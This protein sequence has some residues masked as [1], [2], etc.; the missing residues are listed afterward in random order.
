MEEKLSRYR[1]AIMGFAILWIMV[2][3][4]KVH[5]TFLPPLLSSALT[6]IKS[7]GYGGVELFLFLSGFG[8]YQS[9]V[10]N[11][12]VLTFYARRLRRIL[13]AYLPVLLLWLCWK[14]PSTA[15]GLWP[16]IILGNLTGLGFW[17]SAAPLFNWYI[18]SLFA[19]Y[20]AAPL[21][22]A[23]QERYGVRGEAAL[24]LGSAV[25]DVCFLGSYLM[26]AVS[27]FTIFLLGMIFS[28]RCV[29]GKRCT[30]FCELFFYAAGMGAFF[31]LLWLRST[32]PEL[33][34]GYGLYWYPFL[35]LGI[36]L[37]YF[38]CRVFSLL[39]R[40]R[41]G[42]AVEHFFAL[43][44]GCSLELYLLHVNLFDTL[45]ITSNKL[46]VLVFAG[47]LLAGWLYH[48]LLTRLTARFSRK[49]LST[50]R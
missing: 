10:K 7:V 42:R 12:E 34:W 2:Y 25:L 50:A 5:F 26:V 13:P 14:L 4:S 40:C 20:L 15:P 46:W 35:F 22:F 11:P 48:T 41:P 31:L 33:M 44:G 47:V 27:R 3:H 43:L 49:V 1:G 23:I 28:R 45:P 17:A 21:L 29:Q 19:F 36:G 39:E 16:K 32:F 37:L 6:Q 8:L 18:L 9:L 38:L 30:L 24:L